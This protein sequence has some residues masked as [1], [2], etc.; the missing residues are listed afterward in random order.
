MP[1][2]T[3]SK[4]AGSLCTPF[5]MPYYRTGVP[6]DVNEPVPTVTT[7]DRFALVTPDGHALDIFFRMLTPR[8]LARAQGFPDDFDFVGNKAQVVRQIGN[9]VP[10]GT[11]EHLCFSTLKNANSL[12]GDGQRW[13][14]EGQ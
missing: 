9:A 10:V 12:L 2:V 11:A 8:E 1:T 13:R 14:G 5:L 7:R 6:R 3:A 4:G